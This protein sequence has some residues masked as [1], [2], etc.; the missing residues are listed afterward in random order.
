[1]VLCHCQNSFSF[2]QFVLVLSF[3]FVTTVEHNLS[4]LS[5]VSNTN[6]ATEVFCIRD[7]TFYMWYSCSAD[8][9]WEK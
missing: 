9:S 8:Y 2:L 4:V 7:N 5:V 1:M 3:L 6:S